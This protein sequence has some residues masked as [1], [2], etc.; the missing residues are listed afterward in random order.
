V[1]Y[2]VVSCALFFA[3]C[4]GD[5]DRAADSGAGQVALALIDHVAQVADR[6]PD[7]RFRAQLYGEL[8][9]ADHL[10]HGEAA[11]DRV[12][13]L[14]LRGATVAVTVGT[15]EEQDLA[16]EKVAI[17]HGKVGKIDG[18]V[19]V[20]ARIKNGKTR[21]RGLAEIVDAAARARDFDRALAIA[22][23]I[24]EPE[25]KSSAYG[26]VSRALTEAGEI[27]RAI[28]TQRKCS[29]EEHANEALAA[30][31]KEHARRGQMKQAEEVAEKISSGHFRGEASEAIARVYFEK[32]EKQKADKIIVRI[33]SSWLQS[34]AYAQCARIA[35]T[36]GQRAAAEK[37]GEQ[38]LSTAEGINDKVMRAAALEDLARFAIED[39]DVKAGLELA[40]R[41]GSRDVRRKITA[42]AVGVLAEA[43]RIK[44]AS[45]LAVGI[46][47]DPLWGADALGAIARA[48][49]DRG[50]VAGALSVIA[51]IASLELRLA[52][53]ARVAV[54]VGIAPLSVIPLL[55]KILEA[56]AV[57]S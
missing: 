34:R 42:L 57:S 31:S 2:F 55:E 24:S 20:A 54:S 41:A 36:R 50:E 43:A 1:K 11:R 30:I 25:E 46:A 9:V 14:L 15:M 33:E 51:S 3:G 45:Q 26:A 49:A 7:R 40:E 39:G 47:E 6:M 37:L 8:A 38:A 29:M 12:E 5:G 53:L 18:A 48:E 17:A 13:A 19:E 28:D 4:R 23:K 56:K 35:R 22:G 10:A 27:K 16:L 21:S 32:N 44:E 52:H